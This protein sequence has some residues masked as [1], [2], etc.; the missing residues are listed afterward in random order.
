MSTRKN[1]TRTEEFELVVNN[2]PIFVKATA[3]QTYT[4]ETQYRVSVN[5]SPV[6]IF[7]WHPA[8]QRITAIDRGSAVSNIPP[9]VAEAIGD[10]LTHRMAA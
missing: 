9:N 3:F 2:T 8:L 5:G 10:Q 6:Y 4:M 1:T 7:G